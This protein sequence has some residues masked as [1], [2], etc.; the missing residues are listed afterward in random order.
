MELRKI[1]IRPACTVD[2][3]RI[4]SLFAALDYPD[5]VKGLESR[6][7]QQIGDAGTEV[8]VATEGGDTVGVLVMHVFAPLHVARP[9]AVVSALVVDE[10][11]RSLGAGALLIAYA[12]QVAI[13]RDC[14]HLELSCSE[15]RTRAHAFYEDQGFVEVRKRLMKKLPER[16]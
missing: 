5:A 11:Y 10:R 1:V 6:L 7:Q 15:R 4:A 3:P 12:Q 9:W 13:A 2:A 14:A 16:E 8:L